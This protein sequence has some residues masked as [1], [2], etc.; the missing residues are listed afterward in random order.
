MANLFVAIAC[1]K[2]K[3]I[4]VSFI[5]RQLMG[6]GLLSLWQMPSPGF[7]KK[8]DTVPDSQLFLQN[9]E[10]RQTSVVAKDAWESLGCKMF[11][12]PPRSPNLNPDREHVP[13]DSQTA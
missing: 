8:C 6:R 2:G 9:G 13:L 12:I 11:S 3:F 4:Y 5:P 1:K 10:P 7:L